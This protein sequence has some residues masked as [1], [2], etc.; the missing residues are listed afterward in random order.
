[1]YV[2]TNSLCRGPRVDQLC[3][4]L[5]LSPRL[6]ATAGQIK[7]GRHARKEW[8]GINASGF[9]GLIACMPLIDF[10]RWNTT[11]LGG[12]LG[13]QGRTYRLNDD[14]FFPSVG[15]SLHKGRNTRLNIGRRG[16]KV[17]IKARI[18]SDARSST[19]ISIQPLA[20]WFLSS[21]LHHR[22]QANYVAGT[23]SAVRPSVRPSIY[24]SIHS[25]LPQSQ[26]ST[27][28]PQT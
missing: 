17:E 19:S 27:F 6:S 23:W 21:H 7:Y 18:H 10:G 12:I 13:G 20:R 3:I 25:S 15:P 8:C 28:N 4:T 16:P 2:C 22:P 5:P 14:L 26:S 9:L 11:S 24:P 1:M